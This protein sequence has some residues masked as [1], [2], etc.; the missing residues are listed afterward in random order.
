[1]TDPVLYDL[2]EEQMAVSGTQ[3]RD[4]RHRFATDFLPVFNEYHGVICAGNERVSMQYQ[5]PWN[6]GE[7]VELLAQ[8]RSRD[9]LLGFS[10][11]GIHKDDFDFRMGEYL[12]RKI[13]SQGQ[14]KTFL[15]ALKLAQFSF[16]VQTGTPT[17]ILLL[18]DIF[19]KLDAHRMEQIIQLVSQ[20]QFGQIFIT[21]TNRTHLDEIIRSTGSDHR[22]FEVRNGEISGS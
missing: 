7:P 9:Q 16:L 13:G 11:S 4:K 12:I 2:W 6:E 1:V 5:S 15:I 14:N 3:I 10:G 18:D 22:L 8:S 19:D 20:P 17:P 21:D